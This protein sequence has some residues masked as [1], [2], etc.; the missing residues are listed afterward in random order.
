[1]GEILDQ[2]LA[3]RNKIQEFLDLGELGDTGVPQI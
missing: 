2:I 1:V 3:A